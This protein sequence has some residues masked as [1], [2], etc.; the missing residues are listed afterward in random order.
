MNRRL[1]VEPPLGIAAGVDALGDP[2]LFE[3]PI[4]DP[5]PLLPN[6]FDL[7]GPVRKLSSARVLAPNPSAPICRVV[8]RRCAW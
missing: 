4:A 3:R 2:G 7:A 6:R 5:F 8:I 1:A